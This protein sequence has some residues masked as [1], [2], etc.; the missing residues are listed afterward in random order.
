MIEGSSRGAAEHRPAAGRQ[1]GKRARRVATLSAAFMAAVLM[2]GLGMAAG[3]GRLRLAVFATATGTGSG[4]PGQLN[5]TSVTA[6]YDALKANYDGKLTSA[7]LLDGLK[8][9]LAAATNDPYTEYFNAEQARQFTDE[10]NNSFSGI[11]AELG[12]DGAG[13]LTIIAPI[14]GFPAYKAGLKPGDSITEIDGHTTVGLSPDAAV[15][16]IRGP[17]GTVVTLKVLR[18]KTQ[19]LT[20]AITRDDIKP[21]SVTWKTLPGRIGYMAISSFTDDTVRL[22]TQAAQ[23]FK[24]DHDRGVI[25]DLRGNPGG[26]LDAAVNVSSLWLAEGKTVVSERGT[27]GTE[28]LTATGNNILNGL[29]TVVL[30]DNGSA[31]A[32]EITAG[33]LHDNGA[34]RLIGLKSYGK[35]VVQQIIPFDDGSELKVTVA[36]WYRPNGDNINKK[37][38]APDQTVAVTDADVKAG[39]DT[40]LAAAEAYLTK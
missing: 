39:K 9:G 15:T 40:Q 31:S 28:T 10:L 32:S 22:A 34:A 29:R 6:V 37:G 1:L 5:Y 12:E 20:F 26:F 4:L 11:G 7:Q 35:G 2:F 14:K 3:S 33:A 36:S 8:S 17:K 23:Q 19:E 24:S 21:P 13:D 18:D 30:I 16:K 25:L 27:T 38:I